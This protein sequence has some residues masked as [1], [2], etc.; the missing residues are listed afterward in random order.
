MFLSGHKTKESYIIDITI[1]SELIKLMYLDRG[2]ITQEQY[3]AIKSD[4]HR[5]RF[6][7]AIV[8]RVLSNHALWDLN[9]S[10]AYDIAYEEE[11]NLYIAEEF[12]DIPHDMELI[13]LGLYECDIQLEV[14]NI[15][16]DELD[17]AT[18][19][20]WLTRVVGISLMIQNQGDYR[21]INYFND[22][23]HNMEKLKE[24][25]TP[26]VLYKHE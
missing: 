18:W 20:V 11:L 5:G 23:R 10:H 17:K 6:I 15:L 2:F 1:I 26:E 14:M 7:N 25:Y 21:A 16:P 13:K 9:G 4:K 19:A 3:V 24:N 8:E 12:K 22:D